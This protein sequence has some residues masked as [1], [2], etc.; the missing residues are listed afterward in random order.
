MIVDSEIN[1]FG[2]FLGRNPNPRVHAPR[3][4]NTVNKCTIDRLSDDI[5]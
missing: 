5:E 4:K 2:D 3:G 1:Y